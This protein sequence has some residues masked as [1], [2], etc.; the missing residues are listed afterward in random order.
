M[1]I[2][3][4]EA[5]AVVS[6]THVWLLVAAAVA[7]AIF[8]TTQA[9]A[10]GL[11]KQQLLKLAAIAVGSYTPVASATGSTVG[12][13]H[14]QQEAKQGHQGR[15]DST[16]GVQACDRLRLSFSRLS[17]GVAVTDVA[18]AVPYTQLADVSSSHTDSHTCCVGEEHDVPHAQLSS[19]ECEAVE[20]GDPHYAAVTNA[21]CIL[22][23]L[24]QLAL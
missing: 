7:G 3:G 15:S 21:T 10:A 13:M 8:C 11:E 23:T 17:P 20:R 12:S 19:I 4:M 6:N 24:L 5:G 2:L 14:V 9:V 22:L 18:A 16:C 1:L